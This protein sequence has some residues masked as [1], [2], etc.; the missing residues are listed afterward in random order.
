MTA[1]THWRPAAFNPSP[2]TP[3]DTGRTL[4]R[5]TARI[6]EKFGPPQ[7]VNGITH[8]RNVS[9]QSTNSP[10]PWNAAG[11]LCAGLT[12]KWWKTCSST[13]SGYS[14]SSW[15]CLPSLWQNLCFGVWTSVSAVIFVSTY[16]RT[17]DYISATSS[18]KTTHRNYQWS[19]GKQLRMSNDCKSKI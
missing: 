3:S 17:T 9:R 4:H 2:F 8:G 18:S 13:C 12:F 15:T 6:S 16:D 5:C 14:Y 19:T 7:F 11:C 1:G 10:Q